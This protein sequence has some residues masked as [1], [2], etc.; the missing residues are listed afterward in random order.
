M[1]GSRVTVGRVQGGTGGQPG[2]EAKKNGN[3]KKT[4]ISRG[5]NHQV[6]QQ[7]NA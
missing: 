7:I 1:E 6:K 2:N 5:G 4:L 3:R